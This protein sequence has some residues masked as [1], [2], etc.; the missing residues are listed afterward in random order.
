MTDSELIRCKLFLDYFHVKYDGD[1]IYLTD[2]GNSVVM[3]PQ[4][5]WQEFLGHS[6]NS[7]AE[8]V[9]RKLNKKTEYK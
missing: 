2:A 8:A 3:N 5:E 7:V 1:T 6:V 4:T 9:A